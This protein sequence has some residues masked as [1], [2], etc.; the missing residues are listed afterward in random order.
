MEILAPAGSVASMKA[1]INAGADAVYMGGSRFGARAYADNPQEDQ[2]LE[3]MDYA[4]LYGCKVYMTVNTLMKEKEL[5]ELYAYLKPYYE[6]G[7]DAVLVQDYGAFMQIRELF[8]DLPLHVSTQMTVT[9]P[10]FAKRL[11]ELGASR[12][13]AARELSLEELR[14]IRDQADI[15]V[16]SFVHGALCYCYSGQCLMSS[17]IGGRSG[18]RGRC[19]QPCRLP[20]EWEENADKKNRYLLSMKDLCTLELLPDILEA[21]VCSLKIEGR[22]K[23]PRYTAGV[24]R[25]YRKYVDRYLEKGKD[26]YYVEKEDEEELLKLFDRG[27][28]T[29]GYYRKHNGRDMIALREK[30]SFREG[31]QELF[32]FLDQQYVNVE[33]QI[34]LVGTVSVY[35]GEPVRLT[36]TVYCLT[37][38]PVSVTVTGSVVQSA[39]S[40]PLSEEQIRR[41]LNK[42]GNS[43]FYFERLICDRKG[44]CFLPTQALNELRRAGMDAI[45]EALLKPY[46]RT[47]LPEAETG[48]KESLKKTVIRNKEQESVPCLHVSLEELRGLDTVLGHREVLEVYLDACEIGAESWLDAVK[49]CHSAGKCCMLMLPQI[50]RTEAGDYFRI[51]QKELKGAGFDAFVIRS[52]EEP[53]FLREQGMDQPLIFDANLYAWNH[54]AE[55]FLYQEGA[56]RLTLPLELN[57]RE[58]ESLGCRGKEL[59]AY[60]YF[61]VMVSAQCVQNTGN[62]CNRKPGLLRMKDRTGRIFPVRNHCRFC[63]NT[64]YNPSPLSLLGQESLVRRLA[65]GSLRLQFTWESPARMEEILQAYEEGFLYGREEGHPDREFTR[66]HFR[67]GVE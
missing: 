37:E 57:S 9:G 39:R 36:L 55:D 58:L 46:R 27:G 19:A 43:R 64:I 50:F 63:Y 59:I 30:P 44:S 33:T 28:L 14:G 41:Q 65:P 31:D 56:S 42:T 21:G 47:V 62:G 15:E 51:H 34:P 32:D 40:Q 45:T 6:R 3:A 60:G 38:I 11:K 1:A 2:F 26:G 22:M 5:D 48:I 18:N 13:V 20:Y 4:H 25:I 29:Q 16:E 10:Y 53:D 12:I 35:E 7:V 61:P 54:R 17:L 67:R 66:G 8:P 52:L 49:A 24:V 23:S